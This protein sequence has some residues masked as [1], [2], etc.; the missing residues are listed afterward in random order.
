MELEVKL[1]DLILKAKLS[2]LSPLIVAI[3]GPDCAGKTTFSRRLLTVLKD[4]ASVLL[5]HFDDYLNAEEKRIIGGEFSPQAFLDNYFDKDALI[6]AILHPAFEA[7]QADSFCF[8]NIIL[9]EGLFLFSDPL[10]SYFDLR[11]LFDV[12]ES[13]II[14][15]AMD[16]DIGSLGSAD[17]VRRHYFEQ[18]LPAQRIYR[19]LIPVY[20]IADRVITIRSNGLYEINGKDSPRV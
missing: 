13:T 14:D 12:D 7:K 18:C 3:E 10:N 4:R 15:R 19:D 16:R 17:W 2:F 8:A 1:A 20:Q 6:S 5:I 9:V 11:F